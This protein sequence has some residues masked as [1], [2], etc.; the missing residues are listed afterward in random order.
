MCMDGAALNWF[1]NLL[2]KHPATNWGEFCLKLLTRFSGTKFRNPHEALGSLFDDG[3]IDN[4]IDEFEA[5]S[6]L[7]P[8]QSEE[9]AIGWFL[10]GLQNDVRNWVRTLNP[11]TCVKHW[12]TH[13]TWQS[14]PARVTKLT[15]RVNFLWDQGQLRVLLLAD[16]EEVTEEGEIHLID[17]DDHV[18]TGGECQALEISGLSSEPNSNLSTIKLMGEVQGYPALI[19]IDSGASHN[20]ISTKLAAA[21][22][23][24]TTPID[25]ISIRLGDRNRITITEQCKDV[26]LKFNSFD[27]K[28]DALVHEMGPL[29]FILGIVWLGKLG[30][31]IFNW[32]KQEI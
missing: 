10:Q 30:D 31:V 26:K 27:C 14:L 4:Y 32:Q 9:Q 5:I 6:A 24:C 19:L 16:G 25:P 29:D 12:N 13:G 8:E 18:I 20:F 11:Q 21:L 2:I 1:T 17:S 7:I 15:P 28:V 3:D 23:I 22:E